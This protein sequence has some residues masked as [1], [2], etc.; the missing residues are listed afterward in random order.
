MLVLLLNL[1]TAW[2]WAALLMFQSYIIVCPEDGG[3]VYL[4]I[5]GNTAHINVVERSKTSI[6]III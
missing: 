1:H 3:S 6:S 5:I 4:E 2:M